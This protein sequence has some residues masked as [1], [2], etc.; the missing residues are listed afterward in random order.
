MITEGVTVSFAEV[1]MLT[2]EEP[3]E[4]RTEEKLQLRM[5][6]LAAQEKGLIVINPYNRNVERMHQ[7]IHT[8]AAQERKLVMDVVQADY[9]AEFYPEDEI[10]VYAETV[11]GEELPAGAKLVTRAQ[12]LAEPRHYV[13][14]LN[15]RDEYELLDLK[16]CVSC[17]VHADGSPMGAYMPSYAKLYALL[18][19]LGIP[20]ESLGTGGHAQP[21]YIRQMI[22]AVQ[23]DILVPLHSM[24]PEQVNAKRIGCRVLPREKDSIILEQG[25]ARL[26][27]PL[28]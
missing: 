28:K 8:L 20:V 21:Y 13:L 6:E 25:K 2:A 18:E 7:L 15:Y 11:H 26:E 27:R 3:T 12:L 17:Y 9:V 16:D 24:R 19:Q 23:P 14:Q 10:C 22:E 5:G 1:D 4:L